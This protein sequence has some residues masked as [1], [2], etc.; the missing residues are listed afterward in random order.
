MV[1]ANCS[2]WDQTVFRKPVGGLLYS[3]AGESSLARVNF[4]DDARGAAKDTLMPKLAL[5]MLESQGIFN[6]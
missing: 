5:V 4:E 2:Y 3:V 1:G 6:A